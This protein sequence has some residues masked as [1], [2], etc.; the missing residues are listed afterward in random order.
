MGPPPRVTREGKPIGD[1]QLLGLL[2]AGVEPACEPTGEPMPA[3]QVRFEGLL[4][5]LTSMAI[6]TDKVVDRVHF[7]T[8]A[9]GAA[10]LASVDGRCVGV[11]RRLGKGRIATLGFRPRDDQ[12][13]STGQEARWL[14]D[15]LH[16]LGAYGR[17]GLVATARDPSVISRSGEYLATAFAN[18]AVGLCRHYRRHRE[19]WPWPF[20]RDQEQDRRLLEANPP[21][22]DRINVRNVRLGGLKI[23]YRGRGA[24]LLRTDAAG[25]LI[26]FSGSDCTGLRVGRRSY[27]FCAKP[28]SLTFHPLEGRL[29]DG[30]RAVYRLHARSAGEFSLPLPIDGP[31]KVLAEGTLPGSAGAELPSRRRGD[32]LVVTIGPGMENRWLFVVKGK[33]KP[34]A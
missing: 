28:A 17:P 34:R 7:L 32:D 14:F 30:G 10:S 5:H 23:S 2:G 4:K 3:Y 29:S 21:G 9:K 24:M 11:L 19:N 18:G 12:S 26:A 15:I 25:R 13:A 27:R 31:V 1:R 20:F 16:V 8:P 33:Y 6:L 22:D